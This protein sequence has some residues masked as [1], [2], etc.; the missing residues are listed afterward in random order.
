M[1]HLACS[2]GTG[3][4]GP[5]K[6]FGEGGRL[7]EAAHVHGN[8][9]LRSG[10]PSVCPWETFLWGVVAV[11]WLC[12]A[13]LGSQS[14]LGTHPLDKVTHMAWIIP[15]S[16]QPAA[17][18]PLGVQERMQAGQAAFASA[19]SILGPQ[20]APAGAEGQGGPAAGSIRHLTHCQCPRR[21]QQSHPSGGR[22]Y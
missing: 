6:A 14:S 5:G 15:G 10:V 9:C 11:N 1:A 3:S 4:L 8:V 7:E 18:R 21:W 20:E 16:G 13:S 12:Q 22:G 17:S 2:A 19:L